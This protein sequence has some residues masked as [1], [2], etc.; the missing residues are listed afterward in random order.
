MDA[1]PHKIHAVYLDLDGVPVDFISGAL[2]RHGVAP[3]AMGGFLIPGNWHVEKAL[4]I[5]AADFYAKIQGHTFWEQLEWMP[6]GRA[7]L[8]LVE[9][10]CLKHNVEL[11]LLTAPTMDDFCWSGKAAWVRREMPHLERRLTISCNK[12]CVAGPGKLLIDDSD[13]NCRA[14]RGD[15]KRPGGDTIL[16]PRWW[17]SEHALAG[18]PQNEGTLVHLRRR[19]EAIASRFEA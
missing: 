6:D 2:A 14:W 10:V 4:G 8:E 1:Q 17:N 7:I 18:S 19:L 13:V 11:W 15:F 9:G 3:E 12:A 5:S 16:V